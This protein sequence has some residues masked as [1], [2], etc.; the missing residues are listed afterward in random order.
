VGRQ[1]YEP[2]PKKVDPLSGAAGVLAAAGGV[3]LAGP[4]AIEGAL[5]G[6]KSQGPYYAP[7][8]APQGPHYE[9]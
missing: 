6:G 7:A 9:Q 3:L 5:K 2:A 1:Y 4:E 8:P